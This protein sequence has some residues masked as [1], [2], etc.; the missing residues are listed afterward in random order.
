[1]RKSIK[2][3]GKFCA[4]AR[5][6]MRNALKRKDR[7]FEGRATRECAVMREAAGGTARVATSDGGSTKK[8]TAF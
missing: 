6:A 7:V 1:V 3:K 5:I 8:H 2:T 4:E